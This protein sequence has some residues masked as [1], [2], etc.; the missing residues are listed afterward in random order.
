MYCL[1]CNLPSKPFVFIWASA[2]SLFKLLQSNGLSFSIFSSWPDIVQIIL[3]WHNAQRPGQL[4]HSTVEFCS[5]R[6]EGQRKGQM[7]QK[8]RRGQISTCRLDSYS[9][10]AGG[11]GEKWHY[12]HIF[13]SDMCKHWSSERRNRAAWFLAALA[14]LYLTLVSG[15]V[16]HWLT[17]TLEFWHKEWLLRLGTLETFD[18]SDKNTK[19]QKTTEKDQKESLVLRCKGSFALLW[20]FIH[21][22]KKAI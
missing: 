8:E 2:K 3:L 18:K 19:R 22:G 20:Y 14:V 13:Q 7:G 15:W 4:T 10:G 6:G 5:W 1:F 9:S 21:R 16:T 12:H 17:A 11:S